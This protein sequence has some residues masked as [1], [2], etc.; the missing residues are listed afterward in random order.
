MVTRSHKFSFG[1]SV[2]LIGGHGVEYTDGMASYKKYTAQITDQ[3]LIL[4]IIRANYVIRNHVVCKI[5]MYLSR[6]TQ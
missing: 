3:R 1:E 5:P 6:G 4:N 2:C